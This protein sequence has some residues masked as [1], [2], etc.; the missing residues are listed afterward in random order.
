[1]ESIDDNVLEGDTEEPT[2]AGTLLNLILTNM[3]KLGSDVNVRSS[4]SCTARDTG[5]HKIPRGRNSR[6]RRV[7]TLDLHRLCPVQTAMPWSK[8]SASMGHSRHAGAS[9][10]APVTA[11]TQERLRET[12]T[13]MVGTPEHLLSTLYQQ[14]NRKDCHEGNSSN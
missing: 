1:M 8:G 14:R 13:R 3:L 9:A 5:E 6:V 10:G 12:A 11:D 2:R 4:Y 7:E